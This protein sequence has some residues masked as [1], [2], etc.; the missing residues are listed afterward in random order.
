MDKTFKKTLGW[1]LAVPLLACSCL[2]LSAT[3]MADDH[4]H[5]DDHQDDH[6]GHPPAHAVHHEPAHVVY[7]PGAHGPSGPRWVK[8]DHL[9]AEYR[10][11]QY[12]V[13]NW[14][15]YRL[16]PPPR[17][18]QWISVGPDFVLSAVSTGVVFQ[19]VLGN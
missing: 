9:P 8:G 10:G 16:S 15:T 3:A 7:G 11:H 19:V 14:R 17:G 18:Y 4:D 6:H 12:V 1:R 13:D 2:A 5:H